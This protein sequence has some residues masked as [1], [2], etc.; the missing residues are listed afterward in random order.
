[1][2]RNIEGMLAYPPGTMPAAQ[3]V[4]LGGL[5][6][7]RGTIVTVKEHRVLWRCRCFEHGS[8]IDARRC[9][10]SEFATGVDALE[11]QRDILYDILTSHS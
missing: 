9:S 4:E 10:E 7:W 2:D 6:T 1:M 3:A 5:W 11:R 8:E